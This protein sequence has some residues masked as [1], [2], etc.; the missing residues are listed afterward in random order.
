MGYTHYWY[1]NYNGADLDKNLWNEFMII[2]R[3]II[4][5]S[6]VMIRDGFGQNLPIIRDDLLWLN[7]DAD[8]NEDFETMFIT[9]IYDKSKPKVGV[10][11]F[12]F[13]K[14]GRRPYDKIVVAILLI[15]KYMFWNQVIL[16]T[17]G[18]TEDLIAGFEIAN[19]YKRVSTT[20]FIE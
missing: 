5:R 3:D 2:A 19:R 7:G 8:L 4:L 11:E 16:K 18:E 13:T 15:F 14:T 6:D 1:I 12:N 9:P 20:F 10:N 17:D